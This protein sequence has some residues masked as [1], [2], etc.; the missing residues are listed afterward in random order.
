MKDLVFEWEDRKNPL[1]DDNTI[2]CG[3]LAWQ[4]RHALVTVLRL[5]SFH[6]KNISAQDQTLGYAHPAL[7]RLRTPNFVG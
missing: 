3:T 7:S 1:T 2:N 5:D 4:R 6:A